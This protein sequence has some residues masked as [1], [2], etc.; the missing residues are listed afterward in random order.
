MTRRQHTAVAAGLFAATFFAMLAT[1]RA[2]GFTRDESFYFYAADL[3]T[4]WF[5]GLWDALVHGRLIDWFSDAN[6]QRHFWYNTEHPILMKS[7]FGLSHWLFSEKLAWLRPAA[8][9]RAPAWAVSG[10]ISALLYLFGVELERQRRTGEDAAKLTGGGAAIGLLAAATFWLAPRHLYHGHLACFD[11][12]ITGMWLLVVYSYWRGFSNRGWAVFTGVAYGLALATKLNSFFYPAALLFHWAFSLAPAAFR[13]GRLRGLWRSVPRQWGWMAVLGPALF[14]LHWPWLWPHP[15]ERIGAYLAFHAQHVNYPWYYLGT[16]LHD[17][18]FPLAYVVVVSAL[19]LPLSLFIPIALGTLRTF[20]RLFRRGEGRLP[21]L[22]ALLLANG[23]LPILLISWPTVPHF[24]GVKHWMPGLP[25]LCVFGAEALVAAAGT[26]AVWLRR[27]ALAPA[28]LAGLALLCLAPA[29]VGCIH[30]GGYGESF[31]NELAGGEAGATQLGMQRQYW[32]NN[33]S[34][35]LPW[36]NANAP[37]RAR[38]YFHEVTVGS[39]Q[40]Y[41][42]NGML[43]PD[44][45]YVQGAAQAELVPYQYMQEFRDQE[46]QIWNAFGTNEPV[47][48]L[49][50]DESPNVTIYRRPGT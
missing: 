36:L 41:R 48:G 44:I 25:Y 21:S 30:I 22:G 18:P 45:Q 1:E 12:P 24:G 23:L 14:L 37:S 39:Y 6:L 2:I 4:P 32:S 49:Y 5:L 28:L 7:L 33:V 16:L 35:V 46:Y 42:L 27:R 3:Y 9:Y 11:M 19:T 34:G 15:I 29:L 40:A 31:Y 38:V 10:L 8:G 20:T 17:P 50:L 13:E 26:L 47:D 43:R